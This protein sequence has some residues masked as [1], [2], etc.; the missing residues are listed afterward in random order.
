MPGW[1]VF[2]STIIVLDHTTKARPSVR[3]ALPRGAIYL[4]SLSI[5]EDLASWPHASSYR[6][7]LW[8]DDCWGNDWNNT[9]SISLFIY[10][11]SPHLH[12][13]KRG[14]DSTPHSPGTSTFTRESLFS[15][16]S[17]SSRQIPLILQELAEVTATSGTTK[18]RP[19]GCSPWPLAAH[20]CQAS[21]MRYVVLALPTRLCIATDRGGK[22]AVTHFFST[23]CLVC[24]IH[25]VIHAR[26][27]N[28]EPSL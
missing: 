5:K 2:S 12:V 14:P 23:K 6:T 13:M 9:V 22:K 18:S 15:F 25:W 28:A 4:A 27:Q 11:I 20:I 21:I 26:N 17:L 16:P 7:N 19:P 10:P 8:R 24:D 3:Q 1:R